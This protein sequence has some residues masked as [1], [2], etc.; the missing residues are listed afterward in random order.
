MS[1]WI[2]VDFIAFTYASSFSDVDMELDWGNNGAITVA[3]LPVAEG[4]LEIVESDD[5]TPFIVNGADGIVIVGLVRLKVMGWD[6]VDERNCWTV[7]TG[8]VERVAACWIVE[9]E[10]GV[11]GITGVAVVVV[12]VWATEGVAVVWVTTKL[13]FLEI[14]GVSTFL[15]VYIITVVGERFI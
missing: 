1:S 15:L 9:I 10:A 12:W 5:S 14:V 7:G 8:R 6:E 11:T 3:G 13:L 2:S 4:T